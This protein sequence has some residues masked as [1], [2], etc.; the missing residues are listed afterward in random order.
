MFSIPRNQ[1]AAAYCTALRYGTES[2]FEYLLN[3][4]RSSNVAAEQ[5]TILKALGCY[6]NYT[7]LEG[8]Y[9]LGL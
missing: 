6:N 9:D 4:Y 8:L 2:D 3:K 7:K 1:R 5:I